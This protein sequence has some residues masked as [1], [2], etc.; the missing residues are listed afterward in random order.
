MVEISGDVASGFEAVKD[1]FAANFEQHGEVGAAFS[2]YVRGEKVVDV[3]GGTADATTGRPWTEDTLQLVFSTTKGATAICAL[4]LAQRG[5]LDLD[6]PVVDYWPEF[7]AEGK[8]HI[9]VR[10]LLCHKSGLPTVDPAPSPEDAL[11]WDPIVAALAAQRPY[12]EPGT[13]HGYHA[14]TYGWLVGEVVRRVSGRSLGR[15]FAEEIAAPLGLEFWIGLPEDQEFRVSRLIELTPPSLSEELDVESLPEEIQQM[16]RNFRDPDA[17]GNRALMLTKPPF[18]YND[19][20]VHAAEIGAASGITTARSLARMYAGL[21]GEVDGVRILDAP[22]V[23]AARTVQSDGPDKVL[24]VPSTFGLGFMTSSAFS[25]MSGPGAFGHSGAGGSL[26]FAH[27]EKGIAFGY[28]MNQMQQNL[29]GDPRTV[30]LIAAVN[31]CVD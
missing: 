31:G 18:N 9:P 21:I 3:W 7:G 19:R 20:A 5:E 13:A 25:P 15:F 28:V 26:G 16:I 6:A 4:L 8:E 12:W 10:W 29:A 23:D 2:L 17:L 14:L 1:A 22:T 24:M 11:A 27:P 30:G